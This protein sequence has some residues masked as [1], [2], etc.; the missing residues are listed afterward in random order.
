MGKL[1]FNISEDRKI[2]YV[3]QKIVTMVQSPDGKAV[4]LPPGLSFLIYKMGVILYTQE[5]AT[6]MSK[7]L[8]GKSPAYTSGH[9]G[10]AQ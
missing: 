8:S 9:I 2:C 10:D 6:R 5:D 7:K 1:S 4:M 3:D